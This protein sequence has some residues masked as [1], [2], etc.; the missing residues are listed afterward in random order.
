MNCQGYGRDYKNH[1]Q[2]PGDLRQ[3]GHRTTRP[4]GR[5]A[6][7]AERRGDI[8]VFAALKQHRANDQD[9]GQDV[10]QLNYRHHALE[11]LFGRLSRAGNLPRQ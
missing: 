1:R 9:A 5:L 8:D 2:A 10:N 3:Q 11:S 4:E 6:Y 7:P